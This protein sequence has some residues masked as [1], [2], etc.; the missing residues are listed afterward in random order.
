MPK[1]YEDLTA[2]GKKKIDEWQKKWEDKAK[3]GE[4][5]KGVETAIDEGRNPGAG[6]AAKLGLKP[7]DMADS[8]TSHWEDI[9]D[10]KTEKDHEDGID[11]AMKLNKWRAKYLFKTTK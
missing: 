5:K 3:K 7:A 6:I 8:V 11:A 2:E 10:K 1:K 9:M 4:W